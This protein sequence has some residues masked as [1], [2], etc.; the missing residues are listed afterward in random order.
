M[1]AQAAFNETLLPR[2]GRLV[3]NNFRF[4]R[5]LPRAHSEGEFPLLMDKYRR[6]VKEAVFDRLG[7]PF[8]FEAVEVMMERISV[9]TL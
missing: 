4:A 2:T 7:R 5:T 8:L 6:I 1:S 9:L 3:R